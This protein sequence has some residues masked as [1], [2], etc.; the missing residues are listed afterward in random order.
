[1]VNWYSFLVRNMKRYVRKRRGEKLRRQKQICARSNKPK[2][3]SKQEKL[4]LTKM[5]DENWVLIVDPAVRK[6]LRRFPQSDREAID[7]VILRMRV[8]P[9]VGDIQKLKG[10]EAW[11]RRVRS[12]RVEFR[13]YQ[14]TRTVLVYKLKRRTSTTY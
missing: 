4:F 2:R 10:E 13:V 1:M 6:A 14:D 7:A 11:R 9:Y 12:Y 3:I 5:S 8:D